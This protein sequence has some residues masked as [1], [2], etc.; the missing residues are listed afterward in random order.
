MKL[1]LSFWP[2]SKGQLAGAML[3]WL[4]GNN[5]TGLPRMTGRIHAIRHTTHTHSLGRLIKYTKEI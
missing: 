2:P 4:P 5:K 3:P 1:M